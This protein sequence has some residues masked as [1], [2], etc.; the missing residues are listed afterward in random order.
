[1]AQ[2]YE[3]QALFG[4]G[5]HC[6]FDKPLDDRLVV[7][8]KS[9]L[10]VMDSEG[11]TYVGMQVF[12]EEDQKFYTRTT[13]GWS[14]GSSGGSSGDCV[15]KLSHSVSG[16]DYRVYSQDNF[17][18]SE[19]YLWASTGTGRGKYSIP[20]RDS[21]G[22]IAVPLEPYNDSDAVSKSYVKRLAFPDGTSAPNADAITWSHL[23]GASEEGRYILP[24][25][26]MGFPK[27]TLPAKT[28]PEAFVLPLR[29]Q[30]G[31]IL[32][33]E[34]PTGN[35]HAVSKQY[36]DSLAFPDGS[37]KIDKVNLNILPEEW[38]TEITVSANYRNMQG[39][40]VCNSN[41]YAYVH[42]LIPIDVNVMSRSNT[43]LLD[44]STS[45][46]SVTSLGYVE[47]KCV[48]YNAT[49]N[50]VTFTAKLFTLVHRSIG[51]TYIG[52]EIGNYSNYRF[53]GTCM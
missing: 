31:G 30:Y 9:D 51:N 44:I 22:S 17:D 4:S 18:G 24:A 36:V 46:G 27:G 26:R 52:E 41:V 25:S 47:V 16:T 48:S 5:I 53:S 12:V 42:V 10:D 38:G 40:I 45:S 23:D 3:N 7:E 29:D 15:Q 39:P 1:M 50:T 19:G 33:P 6:T 35:N 2:K 8:L 28:A 34:N 20:L 21:N 14:P 43:I 13:P 32:V 49:Q 37:P 11:K